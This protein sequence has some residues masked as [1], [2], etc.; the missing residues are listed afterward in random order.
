MTKQQIVG[1]KFALSSQEPPIF[2]SDGPHFLDPTGGGHLRAAGP[3][4]NVR[5]QF[6]RFLIDSIG[7]PLSFLTTED[8]VS[9][10]GAKSRR[11][12]DIL[13]RLAEGRPL[14]VVECKRQ[15]LDLE[16]EQHLRQVHRYAKEVR[17]KLAILTNGDQTCVYVCNGDVRQPRKL[18]LPNNTVPTYQEMLNI[19]EYQIQLA[20]PPV[21]YRPAWHELPDA[22][23]DLR[24]EPFASMVSA[25]SDRRR[26]R[27]LASL[28]SLFLDVH[29][30]GKWR[31]S[32]FGVK[33]MGTA[34]VSPTNPSGGR[35]YGGYRGFL[36]T[37][38][39]QSHLVRFLLTCDWK[40]GTTLVVAVDD[41]SG[42]SCNELQLDMDF[43]DTVEQSED[44]VTV[45][46]N[47]KLPGGHKGWTKD[48][49]IGYAKKHAPRLVRGKYVRLGEIPI[50][51]HVE[52]QDARKFIT[53]CVEYALLRKRFK[54][55]PTRCAT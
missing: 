31:M 16:I 48:A 30:P 15:G 49:M 14:F 33:D 11:H 24:D 36:V 46:H 1:V 8:A 29:S 50:N 7:V 12:M 52:W 3:E 55:H 19:G 34:T 43:R 23:A 9:H 22:A 32:G 45:W 41:E 4:E 37:K 51:R 40:G 44:S 25:G 2:D 5:Q 6:V 20:V 13:C 42:K 18:K 39:T 27:W 17:S 10:H 26:I 28:G 54:S 53:N 47:G 35:W 21:W 38:D